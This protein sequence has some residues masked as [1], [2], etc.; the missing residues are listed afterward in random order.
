MTTATKKKPAKKKKTAKKVSFYPD[1][2]AGLDPTTNHVIVLR[3][4]GS[5]EILKHYISGELPE[6]FGEPY[7]RVKVSPEACPHCRSAAGF[8]YI[9]CLSTNN[10]HCASG[11]NYYR[12]NRMLSVRCGGCGGAY[13]VTES[14]LI[15]F[16]E[17]EAVA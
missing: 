15:Y 16:E 4:G 1:Y 7:E 2:L 14:W 12:Q 3:E 17:E 9:E 11:T 10:P 5:I 6:V 13:R 8:D